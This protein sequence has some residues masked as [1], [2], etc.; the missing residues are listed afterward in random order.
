MLRRLKLFTLA[1]DTHVVRSRFV[2]LLAVTAFVVMPT[3]AGQAGSDRTL[4]LR[5]LSVLGVANTDV[6]PKGLSTGDRI[7]MTD[8][9]YNLVPQFGRPKNAFVGTDSATLTM[10]PAGRGADFRGTAR[11]PGGT[12]K[13]RARVPSSGAL[14]RAAVV[15]GT[16][17]FSN[18]MGT[19]SIRTLAGKGRAANIFR[20]T[21]P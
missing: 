6:E 10:R 11:L 14:S 7:T 20:L 2:L 9:L 8:R 17:R 13:V 5:I 12:I 16:G 18:A 19:V 1:A 4:D 15:G 3:S 21:L